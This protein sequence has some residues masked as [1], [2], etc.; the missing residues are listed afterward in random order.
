MQSKRTIHDTK[1]PEE[2]ADEDDRS[3]ASIKRQKSQD[4]SIYTRFQ[5]GDLVFGLLAFVGQVHTRLKQKG[6]TNFTAESLNSITIQNVYNR[7]IDRLDEP[8]RSH[9]VFLNSYRDYLFK[10]G[11]KPLPK[12]ETRDSSD[13]II[14]S[15]Y[16]RACKLL[17]NNRS[18]DN[19]RSIHIVTTG[20]DWKRVFKKVRDD[21]ITNS[22]LRSAFRDYYKRGYNDRI[23][24]YTPDLKPF[25]QLP[26]LM[27]EISLLAQPYHTLLSSKQNSLWKPA[28]ERKK[29]RY[30]QPPLHNTFRKRG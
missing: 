14:S 1:P 16:R 26:W 21:G 7:S 28:Q 6:F 22:E 29:E 13:K 25:S 30:S 18:P 27:P 4:E 2:I 11:G 17:I 10:P 23:T 5:Q 12:T 20:I 9:R 24:F 15:S 3:L 19:N 8:K